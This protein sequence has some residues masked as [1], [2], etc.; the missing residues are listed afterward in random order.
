MQQNNDQMLGPWR[1]TAKAANA[2]ADTLLSG[3][4]RMLERQAAISREM[5]ADYAHAA[6]QIESA[7]D[8]DGLLSTQSRLARLHMERATRWWA[9]SYAEAGVSQKQL[10]RASQTFVLDFTEA[11]SRTLDGMAPPPGTGPVVNA[12]KLV[13]DATRSS[14]A[15]TAE[16][17]AQTVDAIS[18]AAAEA[19]PAAKGRQ[20]AG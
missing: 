18:R 11:L 14:Y 15:A 17:G 12:M 20:A 19:R 13:V 7:V 8:L 10:L 1:A 2:I 6:R 4:E 16:S 3:A 9:E 5:L